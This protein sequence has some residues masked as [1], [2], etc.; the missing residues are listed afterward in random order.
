MDLKLKQQLGVM[1]IAL[2]NSVW[3]YPTIKTY[4]RRFNALP[5]QDGDPTHYCYFDIEMDGK[6]IGRL[7][8]EL[9]GKEA[10]KSV[11]S[12]LAFCSGE[13]DPY[14]R[15]K[16]TEIL[17]IYEKR[18]ILG[19]DFVKHNG[20]GSATVY[21]DMDSIPAEKNSPKMKFSEPYLLA[22]AANKE[23]KTGC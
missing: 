9:F 16:G 12:F 2:I 10:P 22:L 7:D 4:Y 15:Y 13:F 23:G 14:L 19:G 6:E 11:N 20:E 17:R 1:G 5:L 3:I 18:W 8:F 21:P